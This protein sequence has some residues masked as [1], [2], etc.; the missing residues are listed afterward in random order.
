MFSISARLA[1]SHSSLSG[2][3]SIC[4]TLV[5]A[6][7]LSAW[8]A[9]PARGCMHAASSQLAAVAAM[10][11]AAV[12]ASMMV[13]EIASPAMSQYLSGGAPRFM[14]AERESVTDGVTT[15]RGSTTRD[16]NTH[17][18]MCV[19]VL[20]GRPPGDWVRAGAFLCT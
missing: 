14:R 4:W 7:V 9:S 10:H 6:A 12:S 17:G 3:L 16:S 18:L 19:Q 5:G 11:A 20:G 1:A 2:R 13:S 15:T 8:M